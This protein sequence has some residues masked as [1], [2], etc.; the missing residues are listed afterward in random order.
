MVVDDQDSDANH[1]TPFPGLSV[2]LGITPSPGD[3][4]TAHTTTGPRP[5]ARGRRA[6]RRGTT[7][8]LPRGDRTCRPGVVPGCP[9]LRPAPAPTGAVLQ[10]T[11]GRREGKDICR[12]GAPPRLW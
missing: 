9:A 4:T 10:S 8:P 5:V 2:E 7:R 12:T 11:G 3:D 1:E 6:D